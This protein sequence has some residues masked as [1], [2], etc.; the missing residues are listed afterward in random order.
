MAEELAAVAGEL[1][2]LAL[3]VILITSA[4]AQIVRRKH[5]EFCFVIGSFYVL[6]Q[7]VHT[8]CYCTHAYSGLIRLADFVQK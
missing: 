4:S 6:D 7:K 3:V 8:G 2:L 5:P 1:S